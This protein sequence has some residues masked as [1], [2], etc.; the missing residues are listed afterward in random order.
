M[1]VLKCTNGHFFDVDKYELCPHCNAAAVSDGNQGE[2]KKGFSLFSPKKKSTTVTGDS[3]ATESSKTIK[4]VGIYDSISGV[5]S[6]NADNVEAVK[7]NNTPAPTPVSVAVA[8]APIAQNNP[9]PAVH[10][11]P[12]VAPAVRPVAPSVAE[13]VTPAP[14]PQD[15]GGLASAI[16]NVSANASGKTVGFFNAAALSGTADTNAPTDTEPV[17]GWLVC[18]KGAHF[19][20]SFNIAAGR[21]SVGREADNKI[22][23]SRDNQVSRSKHAWIT[24]EPK[25][26]EFFVQPGESSGLSYL[27]DD[28]IMESRKLKVYDKLEFGGGVYLFVPL[29]GEHFSWEDTQN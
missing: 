28:N 11:D 9:S 10:N 19:G 27:N 23:L 7:E 3:K 14:Q 12:P 17:V 22:I 2:Q 4:T 26:R 1:K 24:Y 29:C 15:Q 21:N 25:K 20:E 8:E 13:S 6:V 16:K 5:R 18:I